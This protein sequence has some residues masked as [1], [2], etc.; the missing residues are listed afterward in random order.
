MTAASHAAET[1]GPLPSRLG[2]GTVKWGRNSG[3]KHKPFELPDDRTIEEL[4]EIA[5]EAGINVL[6]TAPAYG[7]AEERIGRLLGARRRHFLIFTKTGEV[8]AEGG[9]TWEFSAGHT[10]RSVEESLRRLRTDVLDGVLVHCPRDDLSA[11]RNTPVLETLHGLKEKGLIRQVGAS[12][13]SLEGGLY[14]VPLCDALMV[15]WNCGFHEQQ[16]VIEAAARAGRTVFLKKVLQSGHV[17]ATGGDGLP[18]AAECIQAALALPGNPTVI[19]GTIQPAHLI[20]NIQAAGLP[21]GGG[22]PGVPRGK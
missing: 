5:L 4:L 7:I 18:S 20:G 3:L 8:F 9:S 19:V 17:S 6:D 10:R 16:P 22:A 14:A 13:M 21:A 11:L 12:T 15:A 1:G 2:I